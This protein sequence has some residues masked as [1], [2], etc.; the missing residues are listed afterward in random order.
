MSHRKSERDANAEMEWWCYPARQDLERA[1]QR[2][3]RRERSR[4]KQSG[5]KRTELVHIFGKARRK[6]PIAESE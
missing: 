2:D 1:Y 6:A 5:R 4:I 3:I